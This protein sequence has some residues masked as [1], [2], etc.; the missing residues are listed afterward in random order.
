MPPTLMEFTSHKEVVR[1]VRELQ[2]SHPQQSLEWACARMKISRGTFYR[3]ESHVK[4][5]DSCVRERNPGGRPA[6]FILTPEET[7]ALRKLVA[8]HEGSVEFAVPEF[9]NDAACTHETREMINQELERAARLGRKPRWPVSLRR[10]V[11][12][13]T[14]ELA[15]M[16]GQKSTGNLSMAPRIGLFH[17]D[18]AGEDHFI[19]AHSIWTMDD[20]SANQPYLVPFAVHP[21]LRDRVDPRYHFKLC[22]QAL[23]ALDIYS[24]AWLG[25]EAIGRERD[26]YRGEDILRFIQHLIDSQGTMPETLILEKGRWMGTAIHGISTHD[27][28][29]D[30]M[31]GGLDELMRIEHKNDSRGKAWI[32]TAFNFKQRAM[33]QSGEDVGRV[34]GE[35]ESATKHW[36]QIQKQA[37]MLEEGRLPEGLRDPLALGFMTQPQF[38]ELHAQKMFELNCRSKQR[39]GF[40]RAV[41]PNDLMQNAITPRPL[42]D[43]ERWRFLPVKDEAVIVRGGMIVKSV[44]EYGQFNFAVNGVLD[45]VHFENGYRVLIAFDPQMP[46]RGCVVANAETGSKNRHGYKF[47]QVMLTAP[48]LHRV[49]IIDDS[50]QRGTNWKKK[51]NTA[52]RAGFA[53]V[54]Q[55]LTDDRAVRIRQTLD[56]QGRLTRVSNRPESGPHSPSAEPKPSRTRSVRPAIDLEALRRSER[57]AMGI[58]EDSESF[59]GHTGD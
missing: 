4:Q 13:T 45:D 30:V 56:H 8:R 7:I 5:G 3:Y 28:K 55:S 43:A 44:R 6:K 20:E 35:F 18:E 38:E 47:G 48:P 32:E 37:A 21:D 27:G 33:A 53:Q 23:F 54:K 36:L 29:R 57:A 19:R 31:W 10:L 17:R 25:V 2:A 40:D 41:V 14:I 58:L 11:R 24:A 52:A 46:E 22:R 39:E 1:S 16:R 12:V 50:M 9:A 42:P 59:A 34:R 26:Q 49:P 15:Q 51:A